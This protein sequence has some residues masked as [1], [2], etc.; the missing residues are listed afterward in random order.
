MARDDG[1]VQL[2]L[3]RDE[4][5]SDLETRTSGPVTTDP[6][7]DAAQRPD[8]TARPSPTLD[9]EDRAD[10]EGLWDI[11]AVATYLNVPKQTIYA[12]RQKG[13]GP[14]GF[15]VGKHLRWRAATV[16]A[17]TIERERLQ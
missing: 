15:R 7:V 3:W 13:Y 12:W 16:V 4:G 17:W 6:G 1:G 2:P 9:A 5:S 14:R 10:P 11:N 8:K